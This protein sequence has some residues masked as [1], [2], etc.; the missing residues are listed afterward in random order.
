MARRKTAPIW[1]RGWWK[2]ILPAQTEPCYECLVAV[3]IFFA[4]VVQQTPPPGDHA[5]QAATGVYVFAVRPQMISE[6]FYVLG[7]NCYLDLGGTGVPVID[8]VFADDVC[9]GFTV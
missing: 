5:L 4:Q 2:P 7:K 1:R 9:F 8:A 3:D 6:P